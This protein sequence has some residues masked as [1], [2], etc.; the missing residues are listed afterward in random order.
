MIIFLKKQGMV[1]N[2][3]VLVVY[4]FLETVYKLWIL[5]MRMYPTKDVNGIKIIQQENGQGSF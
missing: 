3:D 5:N 4:Y 1:S 2:G